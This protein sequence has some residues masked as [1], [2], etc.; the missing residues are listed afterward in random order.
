MLGI[1]LDPKLVERANKFSIPNTLEFKH[2]DILDCGV[3]QQLD[4]YLSSLGRTK[5]D[6]VTQRGPGSAG[7]C[8]EGGGHGQ[9]RSIGTSAL[10][11]LPNGRQ[12]NEKARKRRV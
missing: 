5:F 3:T 2:L 7:A 9:V 1:D 6:L 10:E 8:K 4:E 12:E 11:M